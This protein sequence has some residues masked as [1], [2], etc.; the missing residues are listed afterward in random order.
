MSASQPST[1]RPAAMSSPTCCSSSTMA[2]SGFLRHAWRCPT[3]PRRLY[4]R[5]EGRVRP[6][7][8]L[9]RV[10]GGWALEANRQITRE[11]LA[12]ASSSSAVRTTHSRLRPIRSS[13]QLSRM[14]I[15]RW[16]N[17]TR[18]GLPSAYVFQWPGGCIASVALQLCWR[19]PTEPVSVEPFPSESLAVKYGWTHCWP[20]LNRRPETSPSPLQ[21]PS[22]GSECDRALQ[23]PTARVPRTDT[24]EWHGATRGRAVRRNRKR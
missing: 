20:W 4:Y 7:R 5:T 19:M 21:Y 6:L 23:P 13:C 8:N 3:W 2:A 14:R 18:G 11:L 1:I 9:I 22:P 12:D 24:L 15:F 10:A 16:L 17:G